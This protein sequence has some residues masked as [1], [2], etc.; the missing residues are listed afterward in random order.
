MFQSQAESK[1]VPLSI[2]ALRK[3][4]DR[5]TGHDNQRGGTKNSEMSWPWDKPA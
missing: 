3:A 5:P 2:Y 1:G 4:M